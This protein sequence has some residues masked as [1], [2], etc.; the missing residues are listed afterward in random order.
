M[1]RNLFLLTYILFLNHKS[2]KS[3]L[4][5]GVATWRGNHLRRSG[6]AGFASGWIG[7]VVDWQGVRGPGTTGWSVSCT[8]RRRGVVPVAR[9]PRNDTLLLIITYL[10]AVASIVMIVILLRAG[11]LAPRSW[12]LSAYSLHVFRSCRRWPHNLLLL[13]A[14]HV[15]VS[16]T[17]RVVVFV[18]SW[19]SLII[20]L[21][22]RPH[23]V[24]IVVIFISILIIAPSISIHKLLLPF[25]VIGDPILFSCAVL[26]LLILLV[27][28]IRR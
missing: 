28:V 15:L 23:Y 24:R 2:W 19:L 3:I 21:I 16:S 4:H 10:L 12:L 27:I 5:L 6:H 7:I 25:Q 26:L 20:S 1:L 18:C 14:V 8:P 11:A 9:W 17:I 22:R 13:L